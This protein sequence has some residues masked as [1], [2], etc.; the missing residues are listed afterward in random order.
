MDAQFKYYEGSMEDFIAQA[1]N[2]GDNHLIKIR[3]APSALQDFP[4]YWHVLDNFAVRH[5]MHRHSGRR[6][7][8]RGQEPITLTDYFQILQIVLHPGSVKTTICKNGNQGMI[9]TTDISDETY[10]LIEEVRTGHSELAV[11]TLYKRK[12]KLTDAKSP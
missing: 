7:R 12:K 1:G 9:Y 2:K 8:L 4:G 3:L 5:I 6:E 11:T 10:I